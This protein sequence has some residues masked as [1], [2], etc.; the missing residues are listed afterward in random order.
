MLFCGVTS[1]KGERI[2]PVS[3]EAEGVATDPG[4]ALLRPFCAETITS[5]SIS[6]KLFT[7]LPYTLSGREYWE[8]ADPGVVADPGVALPGGDIG[9][10]GGGDTADIFDATE[11]TDTACVTTLASAGVAGVAGVTGAS[12]GCLVVSCGG[13]DGDVFLKSFVTDMA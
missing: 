10:G 2:P 7:S 6:S 13:V 1:G 4:V 5:G 9:A 11:V 3:E 8:S 12:T